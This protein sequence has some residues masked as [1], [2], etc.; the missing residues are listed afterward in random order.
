[1]A[2]TL[3]ECT[4]LSTV[5]PIWQDVLAPTLGTAARALPRLHRRAGY[6]RLSDCPGDHSGIVRRGQVGSRKLHRGAW[7][8][9]LHRSRRSPEP[10]HRGEANVA[11]RGSCA[12]HASVTSPGCALPW[13]PPKP[14][15]R[16]SC[17]AVRDKVCA[18]IIGLGGFRIQGRTFR[19]IRHRDLRG[20]SR[21][22]SPQLQRVAPKYQTQQS[23]SDAW[24]RSSAD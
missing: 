11:A 7:A 22:P 3:L 12:T 23:S 6:H 8:I 15:S 2:G 10:Q 4:S 16:S 18:K 20:P 19:G 24:G 9:L 5:A 13:I 14:R 21:F 17:G 1:V